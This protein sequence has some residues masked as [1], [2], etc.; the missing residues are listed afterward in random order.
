MT[1]LHRA[2]VLVVLSM[3]ATAQAATN[4]A[5]KFAALRADV[6]ALAVPQNSKTPLLSLLDDAEQHSTDGQTT[7]FAVIE[8]LNA[9]AIQ[10]LDLIHLQVQGNL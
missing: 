5:P 4:L 3:T 2:A 1:A 8:L 10:S 6:Q 9:F 7:P